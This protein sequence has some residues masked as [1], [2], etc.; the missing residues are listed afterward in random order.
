MSEAAIAAL[1]QQARQAIE[2]RDW[3]KAKQTYLQALGLESDL[4]DVHYGL[5]TVYFALRE[6]TSAAHHFKEVTRLDPHRVG[7]YVNLGA[8]YNL[9]DQLDDAVAALRRSI[10]LDGKRVEAYYNL[11]LVYRRKG[12]IDLAIQAYREALRLNPRM[13]DA[14][15]NLGNLLFD[16]EQFKQAVNHYEEALKLRPGWEKARDGLEAA[17]AAAS[18]E[19]RP[20]VE[21]AAAAGHAGNLLDQ[22]ADP[23][24]HHAL[25]N[26]LH[27]AVVDAEAVG[28]QMEQVLENEV[29]PS[30]KELS[31]C[32]LYPEGAR[33]E[34]DECVKKFEAALARLRETRL[35]LHGR[36]Q[37]VGGMTEL[38]PSETE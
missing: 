24:A 12:S 7:A 2:Q 4:P 11:G 16:K 29:E 8:V 18:G 10:Q 31:S 14:H 23:A 3:A 25:L 15:L 28:R 9:L 38:F 27:H 37:K 26:S 20:D 32:L 5:A 35:T 34:L 13:A 6:L 30:I 33:S 19:I 22:A 17:K 36:V 21:E 1:L